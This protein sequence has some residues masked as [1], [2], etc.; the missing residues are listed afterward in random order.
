MKNQIKEATRIV[1]EI[2]PVSYAYS[3]FKQFHTSTSGIKR[4]VCNNTRLEESKPCKEPWVEM[5][6]TQVETEK[7]ETLDVIKLSSNR[8]GSLRR[9]SLFTD[10]SKPEISPDPACDSQN[11]LCNR[12]YI[13]SYML[14]T[15]REKQILKQLSLMKTSE[16]IAS[17]LLISPNTVKNHRKSIRNKLEFASRQ[18]N[19]RFLYW[20]RGFVS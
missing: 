13:A 20:I 11:L 14:L 2:L 18:E 7:H 17:F 8:L 15:Q 16:E 12:K 3:S 1:S 5:E 4:I 10:H 9:F 19:S 6:M